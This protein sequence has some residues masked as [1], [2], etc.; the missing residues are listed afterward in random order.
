MFTRLMFMYTKY[1][2][3]QFEPGIGVCTH[4]AGY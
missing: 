4:S 2:G 1:Y 3:D